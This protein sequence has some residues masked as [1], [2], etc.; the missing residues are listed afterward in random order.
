MV[1][2]DSLPC[3]SVVMLE[4]A[5][6]GPTLRHDGQVLVPGQLPHVGRLGLSRF[7]TGCNLGFEPALNQFMSVHF[8]FRRSATM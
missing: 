7:S 2:N 5:L 3:F 6:I 8:I 1:S 4:L